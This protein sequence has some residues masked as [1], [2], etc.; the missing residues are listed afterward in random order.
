MI[1]NVNKDL[2][3][4]PFKFWFPATIV[5]STEKDGKKR[6]RLGGIASTINKDDDG[7]FLDP[8]G[9]DITPLLESGLMNWHHQAKKSPS[10]II[11]EP[12]PKVTKIRKDGL[13]FEGDLYPDSKVANEVFELA[14]VLEKNSKTRRLGFSVEGKVVE[15]DQL[16][17]KFVKKALITGI[18]VTHMPKNHFTL[19]EI[20][21]GN[22]N[23]EEDS[24]EFKESEDP[25]IVLDVEKADGSR[26][27]LDSNGKIF[28]KALNTEEEE[29]GKPLKKEHVDSKTKKKLPKINED[30]TED[31]EKGCSESK[32]VRF[33]KGEVFDRLFLDFPAISLN[34]ANKIFEII[35]S[36]EMKT[37][38]KKITEES[39]EKA[40]KLLGISKA[41]EEPEE[42]EEGSTEESEEAKV[43]FKPF[44][45][46]NKT[47]F[48]KFVDGE[49]IADELFIKKGNEFVEMTEDEI[50]KALEDELEKANKGDDDDEDDEG[51][52][53]N[54]ESK[55]EDEDDDEDEDEDKDEEKKGK[56]SKKMKKSKDVNIEKAVTDAILPLTSAL[57]TVVKDIIKGQADM[58]ENINKRFEELG[59]Q[60]NPRKSIIK[61]KSVERFNE[62]ESGDG[63]NLSVSQ[64]KDKILKAL[65]EMVFTNG[66]VDPV[67]EKGIRVFE[68]AGQ[69]PADVLIALKVKKNINVVQ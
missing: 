8:K 44:E 56:K 45:K 9:F 39:I 69:L 34:Q 42:T 2:R 55:D 14:E 51:G 60:P 24:F 16:N 43:E 47:Y 7:E 31:E 19:A 50:D 49:E 66:A 21:K 4:E 61:S 62:S 67:I 46:G 17:P 10:T 65:D 12:D 54:I 26:I 32:G 59:G 15:R 28:M 20:I 13:Y 11:G 57:G 29:S 23:S 48:T 1:V 3:T 41:D 6:M 64:D 33:S 37:K 63:N 68:A 25:Q 36:V 35:K 53:N 58:M 22:F 40:Y 27:L 30:E 18:A 5:K 38:D 52:G